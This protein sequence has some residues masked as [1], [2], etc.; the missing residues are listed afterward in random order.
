MADI[1]VCVVAFG[2]AVLAGL[3]VGSGGFLVV[4]LVLV[5]GCAQLEA[6]LLNLIFFV[7]SSI[8]ALAVNIIKKR[9]SLKVV[10]LLAIPGCIFS[11]GGAMLARSFEER[12]LGKAFGGL[13][14]LMGAWSLFST[15]K[16]KK[17]GKE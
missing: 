1:A 6:Q 3:G 15:L 17:Q 13:L 2:S 9:L 7:A 11:V 16:E 5:A 8:A 4:C 12:A 10:L 14:L